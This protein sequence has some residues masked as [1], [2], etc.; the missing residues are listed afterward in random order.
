MVELGDKDGDESSATLVKWQGRTLLVRTQDLRRALVYLVHLAFPTVGVKDPRE[1]VVTFAEGLQRGQQIR[2]GW[3]RIDMSQSKVKSNPKGGAVASAKSGAV[4]S[5]GG[6]L[7]A[8]ASSQH[9]ELLLATL[10]VAATHFGLA[11]CVG[12]RIGQ[13]VSVLEGI[14]ECDHTFIWWWHIGR[15]KECWCYQPTGTGRVKLTELFGND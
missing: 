10:H 7:R 14:V 13:G 4:A 6:W 12:A 15:P 9:S 11:G 8:K 2:V 1:L 5:A 3:V